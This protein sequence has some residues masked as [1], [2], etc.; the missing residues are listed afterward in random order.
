MKLARECLNVCVLRLVL[1]R[2]SK[3]CRKYGKRDDYLTIERGGG[4]GIGYFRINIYPSD[5]YFGE[6]MSY[7]EKKTFMAGKNSYTVVCRGIL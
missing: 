2:A 4:G 3:T 6:K 7:T 1:S 5:L